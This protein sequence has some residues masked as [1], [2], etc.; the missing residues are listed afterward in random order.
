MVAEAQL[1]SFLSDEEQSCGEPPPQSWLPASSA[2]Q[3]PTHQK[4]EGQGQGEMAQAAH[5][6]LPSGSHQ[7]L[8]D[9]P[10]T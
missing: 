6:Q 4:S 5:R 7:T 9:S 10:S 1:T 8:G 2:S 3:G